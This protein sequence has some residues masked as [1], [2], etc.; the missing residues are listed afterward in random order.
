MLL[1]VTTNILGVVTVPV[2]ATWLVSIKDVKINAITLLIKLVCTVLVPLIVRC[3]VLFISLSIV[4]MLITKP[5]IFQYYVPPRP[6][7]F[8]FIFFL[9]QV[10]KLAAR[11][12]VV[13]SFTHD[14]TKTLKIISI[15]F[16]VCIPWMKN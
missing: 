16:L 11:I 15:G 5:F 8:N 9:P 7:S 14:N 10:G 6:P 12:N 1:T 3:F 4:I 2:L 13:K